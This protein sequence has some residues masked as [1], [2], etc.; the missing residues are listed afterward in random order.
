MSYAWGYLGM[1]YT[2]EARYQ[3][4]LQLTHRAVNAAQQVHA[5]ESLYLWQWQTG[6]LLKVTGDLETAIV[7]YRHAVET[8]QSIRAEM[9]QSYGRSLA[10]FRET[11]GLLYFERLDLLIQRAASLPAQPQDALASLE[12]ARHTMKQFKTAELR[13]Y[14]RDECVEAAK[15]T[16]IPIEHV[17]PTAVEELQRRYGATI[18]H[19][20]KFS[21]PNL[22]AILRTKEFDIVH[23]ASHGQFA[24]NVERSFVLTYDSQL[25][26]DQLEQVVGRL[27]FRDKPLG[28]LALSAC[29]TALGD[30]DRA[31]LGLAG[32]AIKA[33]ASSALATLWKVQDEAA[34]LLVTAFYRHLQDP[35]VSRAVALQRAQR[36]LLNHQDYKD[37]FFWD[38]FLLI[39][40]WL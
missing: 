32:I 12:E 38:G 18:L 35:L 15:T 3:E 4:A 14:F 13:D 40:N 21:L 30:D 17:S 5:P 7:A 34:S 25:T 27:R 36:E 10:P 2:A 23:I 16:A 39:N 31:A 33:G 8:L 24:S 37:P 1:L 9:P 11:I 22:E 28:L 26:L 19:N 29:E 6:R 20:K